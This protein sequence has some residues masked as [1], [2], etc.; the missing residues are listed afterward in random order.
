ML[1]YELKSGDV[2]DAKTYLELYSI[3][4][5]DYYADPNLVEVKNV[6]TN[7]IE[8]YD[9]EPVRVET[10]LYKKDILGNDYPVRYYDDVSVVQFDNVEKTFSFIADKFIAMNLNSISI[11]IEDGVLYAKFAFDEFHYFSKNED[12]GISFYVRYP[13]TQGSYSEIRFDGCQTV[14]E[15]GLKWR[16]DGNLYGIDDFMCS[17]FK[18]DSY[19]PCGYGE[20]NEEVD[21]KYVEVSEIPKKACFS[22]ELYLK[23]RVIYNGSPNECW[24]WELYEK[25]CNEGSLFDVSAKRLN[26]K[27]KDMNRTRESVDIPIA[28]ITVPIS[29]GTEAN[30]NKEYSMLKLM[31]ETVSQSL[32]NTV[33]EMEKQVYHPYFR[34]FDGTDVVCVPIHKI[35]FNL[36]FRTRE[37]EGWI[38]KRDGFWNG[39]DDSGEMMNH[40]TATDGYKFFSYSS[41]NEGRQSDLLCYLGFNDTDVKY[42]KSRLKNSFIRVSFFDSMNRAKQNLLAYSTIFLDSGKIFAKMM[43]GANRKTVANKGLYVVSGQQDDMRY[44]DLKVDREPCFTSPTVSDEEIEEYRL[45]SQLV[46]TDRCSDSCS[47]GFYLYLWADN[48]NGGIPTDIYMRVEFNHA[49]YGRVIP[50]TM[51]YDLSDKHSGAY[52]FGEI[53]NKWVNDGGWGVRLNEKYSYIHFKYLYDRDRH[54][55]MY[56]LDTE[57]Y[58]TGSYYDNMCDELELDLYETKINFD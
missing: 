1:K 32:K 30:L 10:T 2:S 53:N 9:G 12:Y 7:D 46:V 27:F 37:K 28:N 44:A 49:G 11:E 43:K 17:I 4:S 55:H 15:R 35:K 58:G 26:F 41:R 23:K 50:F 48:D 20:Y 29:V 52:T 3:T 25:M 45:S 6:Y 21:E 8:M 42:Q 18:N 51:P 38:V 19:E 5:V 40:V 47:E 36:H 56:Y 31:S 34:F 13:N 54:V 22:D 24:R 39:M 14:G 33:P 16:Y 57:T